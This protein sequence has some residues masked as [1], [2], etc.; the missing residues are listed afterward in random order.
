MA[1]VVHTD[2]LDGA[3]GN[4]THT[5]VDFNAD[6]IYC[7]LIDETDVGTTILASFVDYAEVSTGTPVAQDQ[8]ATVST[9]T[10]GVVTLSGAVTFSTVSGDAADYL[11][12]YKNGT[13]DAD[14]PLII[15]YDSATSGL[16]VTPNGGDITATW[17]SNQLITFA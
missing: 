14:S 7:A 12:V 17:G 16:P 6:T 13:T 1:T 5:T 2:F 11:V 8:T 9:V 4:P 15:T 3:L 10:G